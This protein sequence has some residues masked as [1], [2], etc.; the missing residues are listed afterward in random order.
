MGSFINKHFKRG[1]SVKVRIYY[2]DRR[3][4]LYWVVPDSTGN[5]SVDNMSFI[6]DENR[7]YL[8]R[9]IPT[10][11]FTNTTTEPVDPRKVKTNKLH[12]A[13]TFNVALTSK[14]TREFLQ[15]TKRDMDIPTV[16]S[17][18]TLVAVGIIGYLVYTNMTEF[19]A[20]IQSLT[21]IL[22]QITGGVVNGS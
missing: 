14:I 20:Q 5:V 13:E 3:A 9:G 17:I 4:R 2:P 12:T 6:I 11:V 10:Y 22:N 15:S 8:E 18:I 16:L 1:K 19:S 21:D 7:A